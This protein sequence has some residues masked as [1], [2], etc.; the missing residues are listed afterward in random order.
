ME[1]GASV[2][3]APA[4][5]SL[6]EIAREVSGTQKPSLLRRL[7]NRFL[8]SDPLGLLKKELDQ[9]NGLEPQMA[10]LKT[11]EQ[12]QAKTAEFRQRLQNGESLEGIR[13]QA[14][15]VARQAAVVALGLRPFDCQM[16]GALAM[17]DGHISEM[18]TGEGKTL[19]AVMPLYLNALAGQ[20]A[21]LVTVND[22]LAAR[23]AADMGPA[24]ELL[25]MSVGTVFESMTVDEKR[26]GYA[27]DITYTTDRTLGFDYLHDSLA[28]TPSQRVQ[29]EPFFAL[30]DEVDEILL[31]EARTPLVISGE[32]DEASPDYKLFSQLV[33]GLRLGEDYVTDPKTD[34]VWLTDTGNMWIENQLALLDLTE[35]MAKAAD[36]STKAELEQQRQACLEYGSAIRVEQAALRAHF[37]AEKSKPTLLDKLK[38]VEWSETD[39]ERLDTLAESLDRA[40]ESRSQLGDLAP[41]Y[42]LY[43]EENFHRVHCLNAALRAQAVMQKGKDYVVSG[44]QVE[45]IDENKGRTS[46]GRRYND[47]VHQ[48]LEAK[49]G[50]IVHR[51]QRTIAS[52]TYPNLFKR[53]PR[54]SGMSGTAKT[55][56]VEFQKLYDLDVMPIPTAKTQIRVDEPDVVFATLEQKYEAVAEAALQDYQAGRPVLLGTLSVEHNE[57]LAAKLL[58]KGIPQSALQVLNAETVR[59]DKTLENAMIENAGRSGIVTV[60]TNMAGRGA[61]IKPD[62]IAFKKMAEDVLKCL[63]SE[64]GLAQGVV[65]TVHTKKQAQQLAD[66][67]SNFQPAQVAADS[68]EL[69]VAGQI[70]I[71]WDDKV[72]NIVA[73]PNSLQQLRGDDYPTGGLTVYGTERSSSRRIDDQLIGRAGRQGAPGRTK[74]FLSLQ[75]DLLHLFGSKVELLQK[76]IGGQQLLNQGVSSKIVDQLVA[77]AQAAVEAPDF[78]ARQSNHRQDEVGTVQRETYFGFREEVLQSGADVRALFDDMVGDALVGA[79]FDKFPHKKKSATYA[80]ISEALKQVAAEQQI[81]WELPFL[82]AGHPGEKMGFDSLELELRD[83]SQRTVAKSMRVMDAGMPNANE[84]LRSSML[85]VLDQKWSEHLE[86]MESLRAGI[87]WQALA[88]RDPE[89]EYKLSAFKLFGDTVRQMKQS[90]VTEVLSGFYS[91]ASIIQP[92]KP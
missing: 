90:M 28:P 36:A 17:D 54:L 63:G 66:W 85:G 35:Q 45:V 21:H 37:E 82:K 8:K 27:A 41:S 76:A 44:D 30:I 50:L 59:G 58:Q 32:G 20:G 23:D 13:P 15:A 60:A 3:A 5:K 68:K 6:T 79:I 91:Y 70:Q 11:P 53:Y 33:Q 42:A 84:I 7:L 61:N 38:G 29:R 83:L 39:Q 10:A 72:E 22:T 69:P 78:E 40:R 64:Q 49:E 14:Y 88:E 51:E 2:V 1:P 12:F 46:E 73:L 71:R 92:Q 18:K 34:G 52:I 57:Y 75:D 65:C 9:V 4:G 25:G 89:V 31:D 80:E 77:Q 62:L 47:G 55:S 81:P 86:E 16:L 48:A 56:E 24:F 19:T 67:L 74:F 87:G 43:S 26:R